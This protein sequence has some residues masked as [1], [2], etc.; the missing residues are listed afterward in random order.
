[1]LMLWLAWH[2]FFDSLWKSFDFRFNGI[3]KSIAHHKQL[4]HNEAVTIDIVAARQWRNQAKERIIQQEKKSQDYYLHD[5]ISWLKVADEQHDDELERLADKR[6]EGTCE[7]VFRNSL[8]QDWKDDVHGE[9]ILWV[10]GIPG[11]GWLLFSPRSPALTNE[12]T[13]KTILSTYMIKQMQEEEGF[14][15]AYHICNS[16]TTGKNLLGEIL[17]SIT[18]QFLRSNLELAPFIFEN[19]ANKGLAPSIVRMRK[20]LPEL[21]AT[22]SSI[23]IIVD[24]LDEY[25]ESDQRIILT[26]LLALSKL[27]GSQCK[28][29]FSNREGKQINKSLTGKPT[30]SLRDQDDVNKDIETYVHATL[31]S[32][33]GGPLDNNHLIDWIERAIVQK[34][35]GK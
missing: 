30:I 24:G 27:A 33:R 15:T 3:L 32:F 13:G 6:Q 8:F 2:L 20:L 19:Y 14:T 11:A 18:V 22:L 21:I 26:E 16:Y 1:M 7:W 28:I 29:L 23:R 17:R 4:L 5:S 12:I 25:P 34:A 10:K 35:N 9:P 31:E